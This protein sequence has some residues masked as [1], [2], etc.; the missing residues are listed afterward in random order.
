MEDLDDHAREEAEALLRK[1]GWDESDTRQAEIYANMPPA[2]KVVLMLQ[3]RDQQIR[4]LKQRLRREHPE[5][6][7]AELRMFFLEE[8]DLVR[9][10][11][12]P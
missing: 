1:I 10:E 5:L 9:E 3:W 11:R 4:L 2:K 12:I 7:E 8:L 6:G